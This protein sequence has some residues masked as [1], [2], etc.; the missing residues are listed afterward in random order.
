MKVLLTGSSGFLGKNILKH[1]LSKNY[2]VAV[3]LRKEY[4]ALKDYKTSKACIHL[5][6]KSK[7][8]INYSIK[9][10][11]PEIIIHTAC[12]Y[13][14]NGETKEEIRKANFCYG[15][16]IVEAAIKE[17]LNLC[18]INI[19]TPLPKV[20]NDYSKTKYEFKEFVSNLSSTKNTL[21]KH[22]EICPQ[23]LLGQDSDE[24]KFTSY[25]INSLMRKE[26][27]ILLTKGT[28]KRDFIHVQDF[29]SALDL[30][31]NN[32]HEIENN[33]KFEVGLGAAISI[34]SFVELV[35]NVIESPTELIFGALEM[36]ENEVKY[37]EA[38]NKKLK[39]LGWTPKFNL[40][41]SIEASILK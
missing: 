14:R 25:V 33:E 19:S 24:T 7:D 37:L 3:L 32:F 23:H 36:R 29:I 16:D 4:S 12:S 15:K 20:L 31:L 17:K 22:I 34:R 2:S 26:N 30:I 13:G 40:K 11:K 21:I 28:Q 27:Q 8:D 5:P 1:L 35:K 6:S 41:S 9:E 38:D 18:F 39:A 10:F